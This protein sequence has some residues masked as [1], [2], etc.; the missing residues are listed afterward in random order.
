MEM[1]YKPKL[2]QMTYNFIDNIYIKMLLFLKVLCTDVS[3]DGTKLV[4]GGKKFI[5][6]L[7]YSD[8]TDLI[9]IDVGNSWIVN[10]KI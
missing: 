3:S 4:I 5:K 9:S 7:K 8:L 10:L 2:Y 1:S 6:T